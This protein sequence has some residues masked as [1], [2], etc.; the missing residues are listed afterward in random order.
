[1]DSNV[2]GSEVRHMCPKCGYPPAPFC[3]LCLGVGSVDN[4]Q[5]SRYLW[6]ESQR[7]R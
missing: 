5:L 3:D 7:S 4:A 6:V 1:M 2:K